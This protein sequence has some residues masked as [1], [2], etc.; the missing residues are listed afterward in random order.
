MKK[1]F[2]C[3]ACCAVFVSCTQ[4]ERARSFGGSAVINLDKNQKLVNATWKNSDLWFLTRQATKHDTAQTYLF[5]ESSAWG[6]FEG[7]ITIVESF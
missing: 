3:L 7:K 4:Q 1:L 2:I 5:Y 6:V